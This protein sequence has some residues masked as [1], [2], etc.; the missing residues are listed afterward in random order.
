MFVVGLTGGIASGKSTVAALFEARGVP[1]IDADVV[2]RELTRPGTGGLE[3]IVDTFG[4]GILTE[5]GELDRRGLRRLIFN[6]PESRKRLEAILHPRIRTSMLEAAARFSRQP[7]VIFV[8]PLLFETGR[9]ETINRVLVI[10]C[11]E[12]SQI[13]RLVLRDRVSPDEASRI[14]AAQASRGQRLSIA[15]DVIF[16]DGDS[17]ALLDDVQELHQTYLRLAKEAEN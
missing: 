7:Y 6:D 10:D 1:V 11:P 3:A 15:D 14:I 2:S 17:A 9:R 12:Q 4:S 13:E 5:A 8:I 16:N